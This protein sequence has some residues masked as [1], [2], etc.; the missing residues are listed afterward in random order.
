MKSIAT[1]VVALCGWA[2]FAGVSTPEDINLQWMPDDAHLSF[3]YE[4]ALWK[5]PAY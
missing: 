3:T 1:C 5:V 2:L 4:D